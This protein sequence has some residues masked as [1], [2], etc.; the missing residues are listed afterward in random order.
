MKS[1]FSLANNIICPVCNRHFNMVKCTRGTNVGPKVGDVVFCVYCGS[2][3]EL[4][5]VEPYRF[6][7]LTEDACQTLMAQ[8]AQPNAV[9]KAKEIAKELLKENH[10][11]LN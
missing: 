10:G 8:S 2:Y 4:L 6:E 9:E 5:Q 1:T 11:K 3:I 7:V